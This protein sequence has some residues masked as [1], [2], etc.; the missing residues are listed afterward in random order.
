MICAKFRIKIFVTSVFMFILNIVSTN[1]QHGNKQ[2]DIDA[3]ELQ[4]I[5]SGA[6]ILKVFNS[7]I[8]AVVIVI[9]LFFI[10]INY[11]L[12]KVVAVTSKCLQ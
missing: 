7:L 9:Y 2:M 6:V 3:F 11:N 4:E 10:I 1:L 12:L 8:L 5:K